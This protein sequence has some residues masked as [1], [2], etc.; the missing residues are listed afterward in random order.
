MPPTENNPATPSGQSVGMIGR[1]FEYARG[2]PPSGEGVEEHKQGSD[3]ESEDDEM[4]LQ[5]P[6]RRPKQPPLEDERIDTD[7]IEWF[8]PLKT[9]PFNHVSDSFQL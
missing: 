8:M 2:T 1:M 5:L 4:T 7:D 6:V 3:A 9:K